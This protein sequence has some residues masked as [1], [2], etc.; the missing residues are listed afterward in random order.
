MTPHRPED[1][2]A[3]AQALSKSAR[4]RAHRELQALAEAL[5]RLSEPALERLPLDE[6]LAAA[7]RGGRDLRKGARARH[8]R[9]L[10]NLLSQREVSPVREALEALKGNSAAETARLHRA[11]R[12]RVRLLEEGDEALEELVLEFPQVDRQQLRS[13]VRRVRQEQA[14]EAPP[15]RFRELLRLLRDL[16]EVAG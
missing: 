7:V 11:E 14:R 13:L 1:P 12:W 3:G 10:G 4:K 15:R 5:L 16:D 8:V 2:A 9:H 6:E